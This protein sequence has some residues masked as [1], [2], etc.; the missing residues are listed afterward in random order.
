M[1]YSPASPLSSHSPFLLACSVFLLV[2]LLSELNGDVYGQRAW[3]TSRVIR[4]QKLVSCAT[5]KLSNMFSVP[6]RMSPVRPSEW[7]VSIFHFSFSLLQ[8]SL[9]V[10]IVFSC[11]TWRFTHR[12]H[13]P[14]VHTLTILEELYPRC[15]VQ[16][17]GANHG[18]VPTTFSF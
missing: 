13:V 4:W 5:W 1:L 8:T 14:N 3:I 18:N 2:W 6:V 7:I 16:L 15:L 10:F 12:E 11:P 9:W 17:D